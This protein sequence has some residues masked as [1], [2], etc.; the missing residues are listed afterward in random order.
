M[1][2][3]RGASRKRK[4]VK[5]DKSTGSSSDGP[6]KRR[7]RSP[8]DIPR[9]SGSVTKFRSKAQ[10]A[11]LIKAKLNT[12]LGKRLLLADV[13]YTE[14][15]NPFP[16]T[17]EWLETETTKGQRVNVPADRFV[18][19]FR[20]THSKWNQQ[21]GLTNQGPHTMAHVLMDQLF[22]EAVQDNTKAAFV[23]VFA[24]QVPTPEAMLTLLTE[25]EKV[26]LDTSQFQWSYQRYL[27]YYT[28]LHAYI[29]ALLTVDAPDLELL[30]LNIRAIME[31]HPYA[32]YSWKSAGVAKSSLDGGGERTIDLATATR[33][34]LDKLMDGLT[35]KTFNDKEA[36]NAFLVN[37]LKMAFSDERLQELGFMETDEEDSSEITTDE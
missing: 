23:K 2:K 13:N 5:I 10:K 8:A 22:A 21:L 30:A 29:T 26:N 32:T 35:S 7:R 16:T 33:E 24:E 20:F 19:L 25:T 18:T 36:L 12:R 11:K 17:Q 27:T 34:E 31:L 9:Q 6:V 4:A 28:E 37:R 1:P 14:E 3:K 15:R